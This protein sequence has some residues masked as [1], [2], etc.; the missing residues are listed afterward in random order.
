MKV[1]DILSFSGNELLAIQ[2]LKSKILKGEGIS[3][4]RADQQMIERLSFNAILNNGVRGAI[5]F[6]KKVNGKS[7]SLKSHFPMSENLILNRDESQGNPEFINSTIYFLSRLQQQKKKLLSSEESAKNPLMEIKDLVDKMD[8]QRSSTTNDESELQPKTSGSES[9]DNHLT[10]LIKKLL[11]SF[12]ENTT[13][14]KYSRFRINEIAQYDFNEFR[15]LKEPGFVP[16]ANSI[17][18]QLQDYITRAEEIIIQIIQGNP[19]RRR[20]WRTETIDV[21]PPYYLDNEYEGSGWVY[22]EEDIAVDDGTVIDGSTT[23]YL[24]DLFIKYFLDYLASDLYELENRLLYP[25]GASTLDAF[26]EWFYQ[27]YIANDWSADSV[28]N[29]SDNPGLWTDSLDEVLVI[30][31]RIYP[32]LE[33]GDLKYKEGNGY[34]FRPYSSRSVAFGIKLNYKQNWGSLGVQSGETVKT[35]PL[36]PK[37]VEKITTRTTSTIKKLSNKEIVRSTES[38]FETSDSSTLSNAIVNESGSKIS[39]EMNTKVSGPI[40]IVEVEAGSKLGTELSSSSKE[41][42]EQLNE[43]MEKTAQKMKSDIKISVSNEF[44]STT[45]FD[46]STEISNPNDDI[47][48]TYIYSK[49][50]QQYELVSY[51]N[52]VSNVIFV[53]EKLPSIQDIRRDWIRKYDWIIAKNLLDE[54]FQAD[55]SAVLNDNEDDNS[56]SSDFDQVHFKEVSKTAIDALPDYKDFRGSSID[57]FQSQN[58]IYLRQLD[59]IRAIKERGLGAEK[60]FKRLKEHIKSNILHYMRAIWLAEDKDQRLLRYNERLV[61]TK[62]VFIP[63]N[64]PEESTDGGSFGG[65]FVP[66]YGGASLKRLSSLIDPSGPIG[67]SGNCVVFNMKSNPDLMNLNE[68]LRVLKS[69]YIKYL[70]KT[71][72]ENLSGFKIIHKSAVYS[73]FNKPAFTLSFILATKEW[74]VIEKNENICVRVIKY[75]ERTIYF[76]GVIVTFDAYPDQDISVD[77]RVNPTNFLNDPEEKYLPLSDELPSKIQEVAFWTDELITDIIVILPGLSTKLNGVDY[78]SL[79]TLSKSNLNIY[80]YEYLYKKRNTKIITVDTNNLMLDILVSDN[81]VLE[82]FKRVHRVVDVMKAIEEE[83]KLKLENERRKKRID[84]DELDDPEIENV[85][86]VNIQNPL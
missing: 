34:E 50:Q 1:R 67:F 56:Y 17:S 9:T 84:N 13:D 22:S 29:S 21:R 25:L 36:G 55:L 12:R 43:R 82:D 49:L 66:D 2:K 6:Y 61:P 53:P 32:E 18:I 7:A 72:N 30:L 58:E 77:L 14:F 8:S 86:N 10:D 19:P 24:I 31:N 74:T 79:D 48:I 4:L 23:N 20:K 39:A 5:G 81:V 71:E 46:S 85:H 68:G 27:L 73:S 42:K 57:V 47:A 62:W 78:S 45:E 65:N 40:E 44:Q 51:L 35:I 41:T 38:S 33:V 80:Y 69:H 3:R 83:T 59:K 60:S 15:F 26:S 11:T 54:S 16:S 76:E 52:E 75:N 37:Q 70:V 64:D 28:S 63:N